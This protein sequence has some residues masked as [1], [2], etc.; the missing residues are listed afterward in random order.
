MITMLLHFKYLTILC[1]NYPS[2]KLKYKNNKPQ[3]TLDFLLP[4]KNS[5]Y[6]YGCYIINWKAQPQKQGVS[7]VQDAC[8]F[9]G[10]VRR[11]A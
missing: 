8:G 1:I 4:L 7:E 2:I 9:Q 10:P 6:L 11:E 5:T 3:S